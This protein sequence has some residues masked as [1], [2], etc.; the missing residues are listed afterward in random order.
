MSANLETVLAVLFPSYITS[1][2][3]I[4]R[5]NGMQIAPIMDEGGGNLTEG[6]ALLTLGTLMV[7][8]QWQ[9]IVK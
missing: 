1:P 8:P 4:R 3:S 2:S 9:V 7:Y 5:A 6:C